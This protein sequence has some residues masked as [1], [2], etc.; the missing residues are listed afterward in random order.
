MIK[1]NLKSQFLEKFLQNTIFK[2]W[3]ED[4][5]TQAALDLGLDRKYGYILFSNGLEEIAAY[6]NEIINENFLF[7]L[8]DLDLSNLK[9]REKIQIILMKRLEIILSHKQAIRQLYAFYQFLPRVSQ[10][11]K[12][13]WKVADIIWNKCNDLSTD[14]NYYTKRLILARIH[15]ASIAYMLSEANCDLSEL[16]EFVQEKISKVMEFEKHKSN[17]KKKLKTIPFVR[18]LIKSN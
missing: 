3:N 11:L 2:G 12:E 13:H 5:F 9:I 17:L 18:L 10:S 6:F 8:S 7:K 4:S 15:Q 1:E 14:Y 16:V